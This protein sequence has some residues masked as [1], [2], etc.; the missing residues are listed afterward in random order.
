MAQVSNTLLH[1]DIII[2]IT[3][4]CA[5]NGEQY[6][7]NLNLFQWQKAYLNQVRQT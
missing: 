7:I 2:A 5:Y 4:Y 3:D 6:L 1:A